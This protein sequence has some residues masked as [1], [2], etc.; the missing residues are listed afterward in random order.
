MFLMVMCGE[1][2]DQK[3]GRGRERGGHQSPPHKSRNRTGRAY[4]YCGWAGFGVRR[5]LHPGDGGFTS[6]RT[7]VTAES[8]SVDERREEKR[9]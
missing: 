6:S 8:P 5:F 9:F 4:I 2:A 7:R 3:R 1:Y